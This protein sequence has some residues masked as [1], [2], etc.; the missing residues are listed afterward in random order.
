MLYR[1]LAGILEAKIPARSR[2]NVPGTT[3][4][5]NAWLSPLLRSRIMVVPGTFSGEEGSIPVSDV[6]G[7]ERQ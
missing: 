7:S 1:L 3:C 2:Y 6:R 4:L 5:K